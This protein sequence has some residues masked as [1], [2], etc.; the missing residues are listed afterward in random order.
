MPLKRYNK[1]LNYSYAYGVYPTLDLITHKSTNIKKI[2]IN[3]KGKD[4]DGIQEIIKQC[5]RKDLRH[6]INDRVINKISKKDNT[7]AIGVLNKY[8]SAIKKNQNHLVL[9]NPTDMGNV[10]TIIR[11]MVAFNVKNIALIRPA[12]D[13]FDPKIIRGSM[14]AFFQIN[15]EY[16]DS[17]EQYKTKHNNHFYPFMLDGKT[18]LSSA[19]IEK[20]FSLIFGNEGAGLDEK[21]RNIGES[22]RI[23]HE[24]RVDSLNLAIAVAIGLNSTYQK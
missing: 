10:G 17:F 19:E 20:P 8:P 4:S 11:T 2:L 15:F 14:G 24:K 12:V 5:D 21:Y 22:I 1:K 16:F 7:Y 9:V 18:Q 6:E 13:I 3:S 23:K